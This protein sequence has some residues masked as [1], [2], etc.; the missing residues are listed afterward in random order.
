MLDDPEILQTAA[1]A[2]AFIALEVS[3]A[4]I[5]NVMAPG[6][7][8]LRAALAAQGV[9]A[10]GPWFTHHFRMDP[11]V[12]DFAIC[13]PVSTAVSAAGRVQAGELAAATVARTVYHGDFGGLAAAWG[14][15]DAWVA[16]AGH[17]PR[18]DLWECYLAGPEVSADPAD[19]RTQ[20]NRPLLA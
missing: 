8:E 10:T 7:A 19:W 3:R 14:E 18:A 1:Q 20:L 16:A 6:L 12:F 15:L 5:R 13:L 9:A 2:I 11:A 4:D 17:K